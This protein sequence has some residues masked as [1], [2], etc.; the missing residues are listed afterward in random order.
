MKKISKYQI[1]FE[2]Q[3]GPITRV[4]K[5]FQ[6]ELQRPV[7]VKQLNPDRLSDEELVER[8]R[9]EGLILAQINSPHVITVF[10]FGFDDGVP[11]LVTEFIEGT[12]LT[13]LIRS[14]NGLPWDI[15]LYI[16][17]QLALGLMA[18]HHQNIIHRD[19]KPDNI[20]I[21]NE[22][23]VKLG[24]LGFSAPLEIAEESIQGTPAYLAPEI[25]L[26]ESV[27]FR[28][29][30]YSLGLVGYE[31]LT[32]QNPFAG[33]NMTAIL[34]RIVNLKP[35]AIQ[36][37]KPDVPE[38]LSE[39]IAKLMARRP[40]ER[41]RT[42]KDFISALDRWKKDKDINITQ[43]RLIN[44][45]ESPDQYQPIE[46][47]V[48]KPMASPSPKPRRYRIP[49]LAIAILI[50]IAGS[51]FIGR[52]LIKNFNLSPAISDTSTIAPHGEL[53][54]P[55]EGDRVIVSEHQVNQGEGLHRASE[56]EHPTSA[57]MVNSTDSLKASLEKETLPELF[58]I[59]TDPRSFVYRQGI[60]LGITPVQ[61]GVD[62]REDQI[63][64]EFRSPGFPII[65][66]IVN[67]PQGGAQNIHINL[68]KE[69]GYFEI[70]VVPWGVI[71]IDGDSIDMTPLNRPLILSPGNHRLIVRHPKLKSITEPFYIAVGE[72]L[73][74]T[75]QLQRSP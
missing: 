66:K 18:I 12:T 73:K 58:V 27:D 11:F 25:V 8:F 62:N 6:L 20:F 71:W 61:I 33:D 54:K 75:I 55:K 64:L 22:G 35:V 41:F 26:G 30:L 63:E 65:K 40:E 43:D 17:Q 31:M 57:K 38:G 21:Y 9:Q 46:I 3:H 50:F 24:D 13:E 2:L 51:L 32:G 34:N 49:V 68:W 52:Q 39:L 28:S 56:K 15:A 10:D 36:K 48:K 7:L 70:D 60:S 69:V 16:L 5:A 14:H 19:I 1:F 47:V 23:D 72:T 29:D 37:V 59:T 67:K 4:Y 45:L 44:Y 74:K 53:I 42:I